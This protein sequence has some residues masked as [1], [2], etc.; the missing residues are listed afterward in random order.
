MRPRARLA[1]ALALLLGAGASLR[2]QSPTVVVRDPGPGEVGRRLARTLA[3]PHQLFA[4]ATAPV[5]LAA[6]SV[7]GATVVVLGRPVIVEGRVRGDVVVVGGDAFVHPGAHV[8]GRVEAIGGGAYGSMLAT[9][10]D[11]LES[12]RDFTFA[13]QPISGGFELDYRPIRVGAPSHVTLPGVYGLRLPTY[14]RSDGL[15]LPVGPLL[16]LDTGALEIAPIVTYRSNLG[17]ADPSLE[18]GLMPSRRWSATARAGRETLTNDAWIWSDAV[19]SAAVLGIGTDTRNYYRADRL[20]L[21][22]S[23]L[24]ETA[25]LELEPM[26]GARLERAWS[27]GPWLDAAGGP[28]SFFGRDSKE[29]MLRPNPSV[30]AATA[31][32]LLAGT[33]LSWESL[34]VRAVFSLQ[35]EGAL[36]TARLPGF[37][38]TTLD[39]EIRFPT[40]GAQLFWLDAHVVQTAGGPAPPQRWA[41]LGGSGTIKTLPL[42]SMGGDQLVYLEGNYLIPLQQFTLPIVGAPSITL[43]HMIGSAGVRS[44]PAFEQ[45]L[46]LRFALSFLRLDVI[47]DPARRRS[48]VGFSLSLSR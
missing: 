25:T 7:Y 46:G 40:F 43:R 27:V 20:Q 32:S 11:S 14:D 21:E 35:S 18:V 4:P 17:A 13:I 8:D 10:R 2:A 47:L 36:V 3:Q 12:H 6:D 22:A 39:G 16:T 31:R 42:L 34:G 24:I 26:I 44:L 23:H 1:L 30:A 48:T 9:V 29:H 5:R 37:V 45:N 33:T 15:S 41:Y 19:N 28:W 38:Q